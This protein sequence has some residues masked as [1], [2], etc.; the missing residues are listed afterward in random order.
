MFA[1]AYCLETIE[2]VVKTFQQRNF[3]AKMFSLVSTFGHLK[4]K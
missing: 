4:K 1:P 2:F 3:H